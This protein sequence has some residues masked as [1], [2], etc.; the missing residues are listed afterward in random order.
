MTDPFKIYAFKHVQAY[1][2]GASIPS[3]AK[4]L[5][6]DW[7]HSDTILWHYYEVAGEYMDDDEEIPDVN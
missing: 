6:S 4:Y 3:D 1:S 5:F 7:N 2:D